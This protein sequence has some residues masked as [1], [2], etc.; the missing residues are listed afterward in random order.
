MG[1]LELIAVFLG[2]AILQFFIIVV[3][4]G[5]YNLFKFMR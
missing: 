1:F 4:K 2:T 3:F 5:I